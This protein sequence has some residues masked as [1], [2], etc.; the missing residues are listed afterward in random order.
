MVS[1]VWANGTA[2]AQLGSNSSANP[3]KLAGYCYSLPNQEF[4]RFTVRQGHE[5]V[6]VSGQY[7]KTRITV[8]VTCLKCFEWKQQYDKSTNIQQT[9]AFIMNKKKWC[10]KLKKKLMKYSA[11]CLWTLNKGQT[12]LVADYLV[13]ETSLH[14]HMRD[15][16]S[17]YLPSAI[18]LHRLTTQP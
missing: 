15:D 4:F 10:T 8:I 2:A 1:L 12:L 5:T 16:F 9:V 17:C 14:S 13:L 7:N 3:L 11:M 6:S 18:A